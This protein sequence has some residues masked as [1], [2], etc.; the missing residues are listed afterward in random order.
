MKT[1]ALTIICLAMTITTASAAG[2]AAFFGPAA[3]PSGGGSVYVP[4]PPRGQS[5][6][7]FARML[8]T[9]VC[10]GDGKRNDTRLQRTA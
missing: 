8:I 3:A 1:L 4:P 6:H 7:A 5:R 10:S 9:I 2:P